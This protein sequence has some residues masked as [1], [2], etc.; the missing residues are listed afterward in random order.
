MLAADRAGARSCVTQQSLD[1][2]AST[3][4]LIALEGIF[5][6]GGVDH[7]RP[8][9][10]I[11]NDCH[12]FIRL[13]HRAQDG[14]RL[15]DMVMPNPVDLLGGYGSKCSHK[16]EHR[17]IDPPLTQLGVHPERPLPRFSKRVASVCKWWKTDA[18]A[19]ER[20]CLAVAYLGE[21]AARSKGMSI[22][23]IPVKTGCLVPGPK[24]GSGNQFALGSVVFFEIPIEIINRTHC[25]TVAAMQQNINF[26]IERMLYCC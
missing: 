11:A 10:L 8:S 12:R 25:P 9:F 21:R 4:G 17:N 2:I 15:F 14:K 5:A 22:C 1:D 16:L 13:A 19:S 3:E 6:E 23:K 26:V 20:R 18:R 24:M 7:S